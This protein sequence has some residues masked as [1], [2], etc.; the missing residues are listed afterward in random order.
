[1]YGPGP[2]RTRP[3]LRSWGERRR[4]GTRM[5]TP[6]RGIRRGPDANRAATAPMRPVLRQCRLGSNIR[7]RIAPPRPVLR[8]WCAEGT[9]GQRA[10]GTIWSLPR[11][12]NLIDLG[13][14]RAGPRFGASDGKGRLFGAFARLPR[15]K[16][17]ET[18]RGGTAR[19]ISA[20][21][22]PRRGSRR[23]PARLGASPRS[24]ASSLIPWALLDAAGPALLEKRIGSFR[25][26]RKNHWKSK[27]EG[28]AFMPGV[29][30]EREREREPGKWAPRPWRR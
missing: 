8:Q 18:G 14:A 23:E 25:A 13:T 1:M 4:P 9:F 3:G 17:A 30:G 21:E 26:P 27:S 22:L 10:P 24:L 7:V 6:A 28:P 2:S 20:A 12:L 19:L 16:A 15:E 11:A 5:R 29:C